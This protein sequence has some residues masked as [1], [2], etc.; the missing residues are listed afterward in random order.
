M[1]NKWQSTAAQAALAAIYGFGIAMNRP[2]VA[3]T[4]RIALVLF[5]RFV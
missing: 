1:T 4:E 5:E 2:V 3:G